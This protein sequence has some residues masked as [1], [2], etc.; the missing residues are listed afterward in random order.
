MLFAHFI[1]KLKQVFNLKISSIRVT[2]SFAPNENSFS[3]NSTKICESYK[4]RT[5]RNNF[6]KDS[7]NEIVGITPTINEDGY[8]SHERCITVKSD[9]DELCIRPDAG[10][11]YGW[12]PNGRE[13]L[14]CEDEDF[15]Y[16]WDLDMNLYNQGKRTDG[17]LYTISYSKT[18]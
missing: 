16:N 11:A 18:Q 9:S 5:S 3:S 8:I 7:V 17:I 13:N 15:R 10:I 6:L 4:S 14:D 1:A 12:K 2:V